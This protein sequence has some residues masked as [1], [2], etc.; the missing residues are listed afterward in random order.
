MYMY[1]KSQ[2]HEWHFPRFHPYN[3]IPHSRVASRLGETETDVRESW[4]WRAGDLLMG[5][6]RLCWCW[7]SNLGLV[8]KHS[9]EKQDRNACVRRLLY[10]RP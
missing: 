8:W 3:E 2:L 5:S 1:L 4:D 9:V 7:M 6:H 10:S